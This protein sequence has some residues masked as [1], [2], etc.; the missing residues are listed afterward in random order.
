MKKKIFAVYDSKAEAYVDFWL[1]PTTATAVRAFEA[2][3]Q[4]EG[5]EFHQFAADYTLMELGEW[6]NLNA[7]FTIRN[8][9]FNLGTALTYRK[10][11]TDVVR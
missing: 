11:L 3:A 10:A 9:P 2:A 4:D 8:A 1:S 5:H 6:D 7:E